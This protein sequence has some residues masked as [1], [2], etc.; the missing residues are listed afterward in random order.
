[1]SENTSATPKSKKAEKAKKA[2]Q[3]FTVHIVVGETNTP[4]GE[5]TAKNAIEAA[6]KIRRLTNVARKVLGD[7]VFFESPDIDYSALSA[8]GLLD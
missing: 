6:K 8:M 3:K 4:A 5:F 1:M 7:S 2:P